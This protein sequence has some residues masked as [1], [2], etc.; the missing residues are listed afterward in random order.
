MQT[1]TLIRIIVLLLGSAVAG[2][3]LSN[4]QATRLKR[5]ELIA[6]ATKSALRRAEMYY[7]VVR[8]T[9]DVGDETSIR[10]T[11]HSVQ[12]DNDY[13]ASL[14][15]IESVWLGEL[16]ER[17]IQAIK[18]ETMARIQDAWDA[19]PLGPG[20]QVQD[21][22]KPDVSTYVKQ[23]TKDSKRFFNPIMRPWMRFRHIVRKRIKDDGYEPRNNKGGK[24][25]TTTD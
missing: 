3:I 16:Y 1:D 12:E 18:S 13:Y 25:G 14:L 22:P 11:F 20:A 17:F 10:D 19:K 9:N 4:F 23:F 7:R 8:R 6:E 2:T 5:K 24:S 15:S 21:L